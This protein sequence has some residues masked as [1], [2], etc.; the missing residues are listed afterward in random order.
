MAL[1]RKGW[2]LA[3]TGLGLAA[4]LSAA[5]VFL[6][7]PPE[8]AAALQPSATPAVPVT[9]AIVTSRDVATWEEFSGRLEAVDRVQVR[10][11]VAGAIESVHFREGGLVGMGDLLFTLDPAPYEAKVAQAQAQV[12]LAKAKV[13][14][15]QT[16]LD[17]G[18]K[19]L[20]NRTIS[21]SDLDHRQNALAEAQAGLRSAQATLQSTQ[22]NLDYTQVRAPVS[23]RIGKI[24]VTVGNV[25]A[26]GTASP[27]LTTLVSVDPVYATFDAS[28][29][30][31]TKALSELPARAGILP[32]IEKIPVEVGT[33]EDG[34]TPIKGKLQFVDN[35]V[36]ASNGTITVRAVFDNPKGKLIPGQFIRIRMGEPRAQK[37]I[38][39]ADRA[40]GTDQ[41]KKFVFV[42]N[43]QNKVS[44]RA[45]QLGDLADGFRIVKEGLKPGETVVVNGL[46]HIRPGAVVVA[47]PEEKVAT[48][49]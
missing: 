19:L 46:Q 5:A 22:L 15:A 43:S 25:V 44:Y 7:R 34:G 8:A 49:K 4:S 48:V 3:I 20:D 27:E 16:E 32:P 12:A 36:D 40:I 23:G 45:V 28:E 29:E 39:I 11:R 47:E 2:T 13:S 9:V 21:Q 30:M 14:L 33:L 35:E 31:V 41:D 37:R 10:P 1:K 6:E 42:V 38:L 18:R 17:R 24:E 26:A